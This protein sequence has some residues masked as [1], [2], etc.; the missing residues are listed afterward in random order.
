MAKNKGQQYSWSMAV[1][2]VPCNIRLNPNEQ[3]ET[4]PQTRSKWTEINWKTI[5]PL[6]GMDCGDIKS[7]SRLFRTH[8]YLRYNVCPS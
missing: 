4:K 8:Q 6:V 3:T 5:Q 1:H 2:Y 7:I